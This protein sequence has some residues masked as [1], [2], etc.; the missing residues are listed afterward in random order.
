MG[1]VKLISGY[2]NMGGSTLAHIELVNLLNKNGIDTTFYGPSPWHLNKCKA[3]LFENLKVSPEDTLIIHFLDLEKL[4]VKKVILSCHETNVYPIKQI[5]TKWWDVIHFVSE[6]QKKWQGVDGVVIPN[7]LPKLE[8][9]ATFEKGVAGVVGSID[10][11]KQTHISIDRA[12][13]DGY[14]RVRLFGDLTDPAYFRMFV[15][16]KLTTQ[17]TYCGILNDRQALYEQF[18]A[19]YHS[20]LRETFNYIK[21]ECML[22][23]TPY[24]GTTENDPGS[25]YLTDKQIF[26]KWKELL[27]V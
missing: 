11:H 14:S 18:E 26:E 2:S 5:K 24:Y 10:P 4:P 21:A 25:D 15:M 22:T 7:V 12:L 19:V 20:S 17:I 3:D 27:E 6:S 9:R 16:P 23:H 1:P 13:K 8:K